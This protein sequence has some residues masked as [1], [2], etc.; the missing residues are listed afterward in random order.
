M[1]TLEERFWEKVDATGDCWDW[2]AMRTKDGYGR[3]SVGGKPVPAVH[4]AWELLIGPIPAGLEPDHLC[5]NP[6]CVNV[7]SHIEW[8]TPLENGRRGQSLQARNA[9]KT[10]CPRGHPYTESN[11]YRRPG[12]PA[13]RYCRTCH[14][15]QSAARFRRRQADPEKAAVD[16]ERNRLR[17]QGHTQRFAAKSRKPCVDCGKGLS[18]ARATRCN[19]CSQRHRAA[20]ST[21]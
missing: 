10:H 11:I 6:P 15:I 20:T 13:A 5:R 3:F 19:P 2:T 12:S 7:G 14:T 17:M 9:R 21:P 8:V 1:P 4:V 18:S 16:R